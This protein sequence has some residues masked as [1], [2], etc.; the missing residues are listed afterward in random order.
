MTGT[1][2]VDWVEGGVIHTR[3]YSRHVLACMKAEKVNGVAWWDSEST[4]P[5]VPEVA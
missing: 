4:G 3:F 5:H 1:Y 2:R